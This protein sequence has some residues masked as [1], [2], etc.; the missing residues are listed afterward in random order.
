MKRFSLLIA[1]VV[2]FLGTGE[3]MGAEKKSD[4]PQGPITFIVGFA[5]GGKSDAQARGL[6]PYLQKDLGVHFVIQNFPGAGGRIG[7]TKL[8]KSKP[9]GY[10]IGL[11]PLPSVILGEYLAPVEYKTT[12]FT[13]IFSCF[14]TPQ[15]LAVPS[16]TYQ[17]I[18]EFVKAGKLKP[19]SNASPGHGT[20]SHLAGIVV[21]D[22]LGLKEVR[23]VH[24]DSSGQAIASLAGKHLDF[25]VME[26]SSTV[27]L[28][29]AGKLKPLVV[30]SDERDSA[31]P[32][33]PTLKELGLK[34]TT[35]AGIVGFFGPPHFP[36]E[37]VKIL[38][39]AFTKAAADP[40]FLDWAQKTNINIVLMD[41]EKLRQAIKVMDKEVEKY[42]EFLVTSK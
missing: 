15:V 35:M 26:I 11:L 6:V 14:G 12:E 8:F 36:L 2:L 5:P 13:P 41:H 17:N 21:A 22:G 27:P 34:I 25:S 3:M 9:D 24:F 42:K 37:K 29:R 16:D 1:G 20:S 23:H 10:T 39:A 40:Q 33:V 32:Q 18:D 19:L 28:I 31:F 30:I 7:S 4:F 38:E